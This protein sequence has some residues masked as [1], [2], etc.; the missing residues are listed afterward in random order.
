MSLAQIAEAHPVIAL[1]RCPHAPFS[2][3]LYALAQ[4]AFDAGRRGPLASI[5][6]LLFPSAAAADPAEPVLVVRAN[7]L[8]DGERFT[9]PGV[10]VVRGDRI[11]SLQVGDAPHD[12]TIVELGDA[13][14]LPGLIDCHTHVT[15]FIKKTAYEALPL[16]PS[17]VADSTAES[18]LKALKNAATLLANGFTTLRDVGSFGPGVDVA[19]RDAIGRGLVL[20]PRMLVAGKSLAITGGHADDNGRAPWV[21]VD[22]EYEYATAHGPYGF[23]ERVRKNL[24]AHVD[25]IKITATGGV[26]S[27]GDAWNAPQFNPDEVAAVTDEAHKFGLRVAAHAHGD[28]GIALAVHG[29]CDSIEHCTGVEADTAHEMQQRGTMMVPTLWASESIVAQS[30]GA[31]RYTPEVIEKARHAVA[32]RDAGV[33]RAIAAGV[34]FAYGTDCGVFPHEQN[35][36]DFALMQS[37]GMTPA[38]VLKSATSNA[39]DLLGTRDRGRIAAGLLADLVAFRGDLRDGVAPLVEPPVFLMLGGRRLN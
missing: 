39:A 34:T 5:A 31:V 4:H 2:W 21:H 19:L 28:P 15:A 27:H 20:G 26:L 38:D 17:V 33:Q 36:R 7:R 22:E 6:G 30:D 1:C 10:C 24:K 35:N 11:V 16:T 37:L 9:S 14:L 29:G 13:T 12:A 18:A 3:R 32:A 25:L 8:F 23:R